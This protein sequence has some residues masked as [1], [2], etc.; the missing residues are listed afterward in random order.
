MA[1]EARVKKAEQ[2][3]ANA[4]KAAKAAEPKKNKKNGKKAVKKLLIE[5]WMFI[6]RSCSDILDHYQIPVPYRLHLMGLGRDPVRI[7]I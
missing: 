6:M 5:I 4:E 2:E 7:I 1:P 3:L